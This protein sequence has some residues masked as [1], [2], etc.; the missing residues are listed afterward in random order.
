MVLKFLRNKERSRRIVGMPPAQDEQGREDILN[1]L[2]DQGEEGLRQRKGMTNAQIKKYER[3]KQKAEYREWLE[4][5]RQE[6]LG[7][8]LEEEEE[9]RER[10]FAQD[11][12]EKEEEK[13]A[14]ILLAKTHRLREEAER[15]SH[16]AR[17]EREKAIEKLHFYLLSVLRQQ[18]P[19]NVAQPSEQSIET[20]LNVRG[21]VVS[22]KDVSS[23]CNI[24][25][26]QMD[27]QSLISGVNSIDKSS[28]TLSSSSSRD[29]RSSSSSNRFDDDA[30][31]DMYM[32]R[33][34]DDALCAFLVQG[35]ENI[36]VMTQGELRSLRAKVATAGRVK[37]PGSGH[38]RQRVGHAPI[39]LDL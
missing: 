39:R 32:G 37:F 33:A 28:D 34:D 6:Q 22:V 27:I 5:K 9:R 14:A 3:K 11:E 31:T 29:S 16:E 8:Q 35:N 20:V 36:A 7:R 17:A 21:H 30:T 1:P 10:D 26:G 13:K 2:P 38:D 23:D 12:R 24:D 25:L 4:F 19:A 15:R 18:G